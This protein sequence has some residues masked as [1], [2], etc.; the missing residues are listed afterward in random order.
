M[1]GRWPGGFPS[2]LQQEPENGFGGGEFLDIDGIVSALQGSGNAPSAPLAGTTPGTDAVPA[3]F[4]TNAGDPGGF[5][6]DL[7]F[8]GEGWTPDAESQVI[9]A[10]ELVSSMFEGDL[11]DTLARDGTV[12]DDKQLTLA[13]EDL[14]G[15]VLGIG[16][17]SFPAGSDAP[18]GA[19][20]AGQIRFD[21]ALVL[22][23][24]GLDGVAYHE[25][26]HTLGYGI[27]PVWD[28]LLAVTP[29]GQLRFTGENA[30]ATYV[31]DFGAFSAGDPF[32]SAGVPVDD[33]GDHL[34]VDVFG[35]DLIESGV[36]NAGTPAEANLFVLD[37]AVFE[38]LGYD[39]HIED[40]LLNT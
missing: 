11:P 21:D 33:D 27:G 32:A 28:S 15:S 4:A 35:P 5:N 25:I 14:A 18:A 1:D 38:D 19:D 13:V 29:D 39:T 10:A 7:L 37:M 8:V 2:T 16:G 6:I 3:S 36:I 40:V 30:A 22:N 26:M 34:D 12:I 31:N 24:D 20:A 9:E 17:T 23:L